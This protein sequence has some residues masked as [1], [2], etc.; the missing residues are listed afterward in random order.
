MPLR[1]KKTLF[2]IFL[3]AEK[4]FKNTKSNTALVP[5]SPKD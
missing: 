2:S 5:L 4:L 3:T 1:E